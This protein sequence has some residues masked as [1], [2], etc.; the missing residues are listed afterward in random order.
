MT[1]TGKQLLDEALT[2]NQTAHF[3]IIR[4]FNGSPNFLNYILVEQRPETSIVESIKQSTSLGDIAR[5]KWEQKPKW[6]KKISSEVRRL[7]DVSLC[8]LAARALNLEACAALTAVGANGTLKDSNHR[9]PSDYAKMFM[10]EAFP[11][12][13][14]KTIKKVCKALTQGQLLPR[15]LPQAF[16]V[17]RR[18]GYD[19]I[20]FPVLKCS[21]IRH[22]LYEGNLVQN[23][24]GKKYNNYRQD[25]MI[26]ELNRA[27]F[28]DYKENGLNLALGHEKPR[29][30]A[31][32]ADAHLYDAGYLTN[33]LPQDAI[34]NNGLWKTIEREIRQLTQQHLCLHIYTGGVFTTPVDVKGPKE[35]THKV[36]GTREVHVPTHLF[37]VV[38]TFDYGFN[39]RAFA[40]LVPN[41]PTG[42]RQ[43]VSVQRIQEL[44]GVDFLGFYQI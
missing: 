13:L 43:Y 8:H 28:A 22:L 35:I 37:K 16:Y 20:H 26:P 31:R 44:T 25:P 4:P 41:T 7:G 40:I 42:T 23:V 30:D 19:V 17:Y 9:S 6:F 39:W 24:D 14:S 27:T 32:D 3:L 15:T 11:L 36:I 1:V 5:L 10:V 12:E 29:A 33:I 18:E 34:L 21:I 2:H 38:Y